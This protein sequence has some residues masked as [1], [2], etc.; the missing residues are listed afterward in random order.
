MKL[1]GHGYLTPLDPDTPGVLMAA[2]ETSC[3]EFILHVHMSVYPWKPAFVY[4]LMLCKC[5]VLADTSVTSVI[6]A[7]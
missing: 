1:Q 5:G 3:Q 2:L 6:F 7:C 4:R